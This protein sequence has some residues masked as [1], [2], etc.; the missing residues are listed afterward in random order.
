MKKLLFLDDDEKRITAFIKKVPSA[1]IYRTAEGIIKAIENTD[2]IDVLFLD[3]DLGGEIM[4]DSNRPDTGM[5][6]VRYIEANKPAINHIFIHT[7]NP[8]ASIEM[9]NRLLKLGYDAIRLPF[10]MLLGS[11]K[12]SIESG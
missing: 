1:K 5:E 3:H 7:M 9:Y 2:I 6:V 10:P 4:V 8:V 12:Y 11:I